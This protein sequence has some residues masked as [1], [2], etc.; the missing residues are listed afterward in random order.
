MTD[1]PTPPNPGYGAPAPQPLPVNQRPWWKATWALI[2]AGLLVG[3][4]IG[5]ASGSATKKEKKVTVAGPTTF[6]TVTDTATETPPV[7]TTTPTVVRTI[8]TKT[9]VQTVTY[10]PPVKIA[11][12]DG[13]YRVGSD[14]KT[15]TYHTEGGDCY[16]EEDGK[17]TGLDSIITNDNITG[18][19]TIDIG[20]NVYSFKTSGGC[21]W[22]RR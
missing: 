6:A 3:L 9:R 4:V 21:D 10:T 12:S 20:S 11:F 5:T 14:I 15:G 19:T 17:G 18:P 2:G 16:Y 22:V 8:A 13:T 7:V 1:Y